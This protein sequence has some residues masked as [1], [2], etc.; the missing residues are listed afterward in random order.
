M[1]D[2]SSSRRLSR[3]DRRRNDRLAALRA[4]IT[5]LRMTSPFGPT[6]LLW[7]GPTQVVD[8]ADG[9]WV[10]GQVVAVSFRARAVAVSR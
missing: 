1:S 9:P 10:R 2:S 5:R 7:F 6:V 8:I 4:V 3:G